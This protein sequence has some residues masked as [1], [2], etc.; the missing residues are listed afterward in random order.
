M[1]EPVSFEL[2][3]AALIQNRNGP[4]FEDFVVI[5]QK[6]SQKDPV[7]VRTLMS[8]RLIETLNNQLTI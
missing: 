2:F 8:S 1:V 3:Q 4:L 6:L 7:T 5:L